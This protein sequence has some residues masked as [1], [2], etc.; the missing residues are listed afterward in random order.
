M[1]TEG[2]YYKFLPNPQNVITNFIDRNPHSFNSKLIP[3]H[4]NPIPLFKYSQ[5]N[6]K[7]NK[8]YLEFFSKAADAKKDMDGIINTAAIKFNWRYDFTS[9]GA[10]FVLDVPYRGGYGNYKDY[11]EIERT[12][13]VPALGELIKLYKTE[14]ELQSLNGFIWSSTLADSKHAWAFDGKKVKA[15]DM[16]KS[17]AYLVPLLAFKKNEI[18]KND[19]LNVLCLNPINFYNNEPAN[20]KKRVITKITLNDI[21]KK[22]KTL[23]DIEPVLKKYLK[24]KCTPDA[25]STGE[26]YKFYLK[27]AYIGWNYTIDAIELYKGELMLTYWTGGDSTDENVSISFDELPQYPGKTT[28]QYNSHARTTCKF[29][30][31]DM[32]ETAQKFLFNIIKKYGEI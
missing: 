24:N 14:K 26:A 32:L 16:E 18:Y 3:V 31:E 28:S 9:R 8:A 25:Y 7:N 10:G 15:L 6:Y 13:Y 17:T 27:D 5:S 29:D 1:S 19:F 4:G 21:K 22:Y 11:V 2:R 23:R 20:F 12:N 30:Y